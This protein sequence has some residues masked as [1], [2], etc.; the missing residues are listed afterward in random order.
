MSDMCECV[1]V[2]LSPHSELL[3]EK[4]REKYRKWLKGE[5]GR[6]DVILIITLGYDWKAPQEK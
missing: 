5:L 6:P 1:F 3:K 2:L 4:R